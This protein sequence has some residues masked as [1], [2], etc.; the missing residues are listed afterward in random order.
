[1][2]LRYLYPQADVDGAWDLGQALAPLAGDGVLI[3]GSGSL[4]HNLFEVQA[5]G[6]RLQAYAAEFAA[7]VAAVVV[8]G[9]LLS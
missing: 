4:T 6:A 5:E 3:V 1:M 7:W 2:P 9:D 8:A